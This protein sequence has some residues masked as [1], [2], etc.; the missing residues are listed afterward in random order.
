M[1][2]W[3][4][5]IACIVFSISAQAQKGILWDKV[6]NI[7]VA[8]ASIYTSANGK[9]SAAL[10]DK[11]GHFNIT[12][13]FK[14]LTVSHI[15]YAKR[16]ITSLSDTIFLEPTEVLI[17]EV[18]VS[19]VEPEWIKAKLNR[20]VKER[21]TYYQTADIYLPYQ[22]DKSNIRDTCGYAFSSRG[23]LYVPSIRHLDKDS[24]YQV[25]PTENT[26]YYNDTTAN[27]DFH[28]MALMLYEN[29]VAEMDRKF[30]RQH[31]FC[32]NKEYESA[33]GNT[34]QLVFWSDKYKDDRGMIVIDTARCV[35][36]EASRSTGMECNLHEKMNPFVR[37]V[38]RSVAGLKYDD[39]TIDNHITFRETNGMLIP[40]RITYKYCERFS[41][42]SKPLRD[43]ERANYFFNKEASLTLA[44]S[45]TYKNGLTDRNPSDRYYDI[46]HDPN[47]AIIYIE[48]KR[49]SINRIAMK[50]MPRSYKP[51]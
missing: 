27:V 34:V 50:Q 12:F 6:N 7:P 31:R 47:F 48:K 4:Y 18:T 36:L 42:K 38:F 45:P 5:I 43:S 14:E 23:T 16:K 32:E 44:P 15:S 20:F 26:I 3:F 1:K 19:N 10:S 24:M 28:D 9:T 51:L 37:S 39:W 11:E 30:I 22:Y 41:M 49:H 2:K 29:V 17:Q 13:P 33:D 25:A 21:K 8:H 46:P 35:I 40:S